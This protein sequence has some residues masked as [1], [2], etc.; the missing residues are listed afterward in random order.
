MYNTDFISKITH[1]IILI[2][3]NN[4][5]SITLAIIYYISTCNPNYILA[6]TL[7]L[8]KPE[9]ILNPNPNY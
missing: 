2:F 3:K 9:S 6:L 4:Y 8:L 5:V 1:Y 7:I